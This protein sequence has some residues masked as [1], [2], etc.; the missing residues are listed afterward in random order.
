MARLRGI[1]AVWE[2]DLKRF[3]RKRKRLSLVWGML[4][5]FSELDLYVALR[6]SFHMQ[7]MSR[8]MLIILRDSMSREH[9][10]PELRCSLQIHLH[11]IQTEH[12]AMNKILQ[13]LEG[14]EL[15]EVVTGVKQKQYPRQMAFCPC[16]HGT[17]LMVA[18][19]LAR[20]AGWACASL[21]QWVMEGA[22]HSP[23][24]FRQIVSVFRQLPSLFKHFATVSKARDQLLASSRR[25]TLEEDYHVLEDRLWRRNFD[26]WLALRNTNLEHPLLP[27]ARQLIQEYGCV[28]WKH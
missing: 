13:T 11:C 27:R 18:Q 10:D 2:N 5:T 16:Q 15:L 9:Q 12:K 1:R 8:S 19:M 23:L 24:L 25:Q 21:E 6:V 20:L 28:Y 26:L 3:H 14:D 17:S 7:R 4:Q 22:E